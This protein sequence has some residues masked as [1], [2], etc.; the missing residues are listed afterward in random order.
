MTE[1]YDSSNIAQM[2]EKQWKKW[3]LLTQQRQQ[4]EVASP[5][6]T[7]TVSRERGSGGGGMRRGLAPAGTCCPDGSCGPRVHGR[8]G[9]HG[10]PW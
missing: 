2:V 9:L 7:V 6:P 10:P 8:A 1:M 5:F 3:L 4:G